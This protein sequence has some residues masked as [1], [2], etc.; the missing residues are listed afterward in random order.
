MELSCLYTGIH[1]CALTEE[2]ALLLGVNT[3]NLV[4]DEQHLMIIKIPTVKYAVVFIRL[5]KKRQL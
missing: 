4:V 1:T 5:R 3:E 2:E